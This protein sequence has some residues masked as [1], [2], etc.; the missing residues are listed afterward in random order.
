[1]LGRFADQRI[2]ARREALDSMNEQGQV[3]MGKPRERVKW[4]SL[5]TRKSLV[6]DLVEQVPGY[7]SAAVHRDGASTLAYDL[8]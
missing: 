4:E 6:Q 2:K 8:A 7:A 1:M 3:D 5:R